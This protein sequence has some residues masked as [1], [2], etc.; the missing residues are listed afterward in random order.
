MEFTG[1]DDDPIKKKQTKHST[2]KRPPTT[3]SGVGIKGMGRLCVSHGVIGTHCT[4]F[5]IVHYYPK[6]NY[7]TPASLRDVGGGGGYRVV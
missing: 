4:S 5:K 6:S 3:M 1:H 2:G 7:C